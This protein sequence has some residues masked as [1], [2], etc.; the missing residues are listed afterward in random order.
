MPETPERLP[1]RKRVQQRRDDMKQGGSAS[2]PSNPTSNKSEAV[3][4][5]L[6]QVVTNEKNRNFCIRMH[7]RRL[8]LQFQKNGAKGNKMI[9]NLLESGEEIINNKELIFDEHGNIY[10]I[11]G[12][13]NANFEDSKYRKIPNGGGKSDVSG[14]KSKSFSEALAVSK[15]K[16]SHFPVVYVIWR[17]EY[18][19]FDGREFKSIPLLKEMF[20]YSDFKEVST[21]P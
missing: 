17:E 20:T 4:K 13:G 2:G 6:A 5:L 7:K 21:G 8:M 15:L 1:F 3:K 12:S 9:E 10:P 14:D 16:K 18:D 11:S 19:R